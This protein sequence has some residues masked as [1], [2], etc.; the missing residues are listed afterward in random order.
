MYRTAVWILASISGVLLAM[1][2]LVVSTLGGFGVSGRCSQ[3]AGAP[4]CAPQP[5]QIILSFPPQ[6]SIFAVAVVLL[7]LA[8][9]IGLPA[10]I[11]SPILAERR[12]ASSKTP[13]LVISLIATALLIIQLMFVLLIVEHVTVEALSPELAM[14]VTCINATG[15]GPQPCVTGPLAPLLALAGLS[16]GPVLPALVI[17]LPAWTMALVRTACGR[18]WGWFVAVAVLSPVGALLY[19]FKGLEPQR[20]SAQA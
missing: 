14:P 5:V 11:A 2:A 10:W 9:L 20:V 17:G 1:S 16:L 12:G 13:I 7:L 8:V 15:P 6:G 3:P 4:T 18:Q 19:A